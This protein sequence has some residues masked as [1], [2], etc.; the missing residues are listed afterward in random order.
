MSAA[1][2]VES[3]HPV[4]KCT[5]MY[6]HRRFGY[7]NFDTNQLLARTPR[8]GIELTD[9]GEMHCSTCAQ[10]KQTRVAKTTRDTSES[11]PTDRVGAVICS[12]L[13]GPITPRDR[14]NNMYLI[15]F[16]DHKTNY[17]RV[18]LFKTKDQAA[19]K[20][21][22]FL[23]YFEKRYDCRVNVLH[24]DGGGEY[25]NGDL[26]CCGTRVARQVTEAGIQAG[27]GKAERMHWTII[28]MVR[29]MIFFVRCTLFF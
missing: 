13:K 23:V 10:G 8:S 28:K 27:N 16:V 19:K 22:Q 29:C 17:C 11:A 18:F 5:L 9:H 14:R 4:Q 3:G 24:I 25:K 26:C 20:F 12:D 21:E 15:N 6:F 1:A 7:L 2:T